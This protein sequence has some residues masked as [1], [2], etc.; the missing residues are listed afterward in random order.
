MLVALVHPPFVRSLGN[1]PA[2][3]SALTAFLQ[4]EGIDA[5]PMDWNAEFVNYVLSQWTR[6]EPLIVERLDRWAGE[7]KSD[8]GANRI[9]SLR[10]VVVPLIAQT[11][12]DIVRSENPPANARPSITTSQLVQQSLR[13]LF[14]VY[15]FG[16]LFLWDDLLHVPFGRLSEAV[17]R[18]CGDSLWIDFIASRHIP[19]PDILG[20]SLLSEQQLPYAMLLSR[21]LRAGRQDL[22]LVA[23]GSYITEVAPGLLEHPAVFDYFDHLVVHE[24]ET[25]LLR[26]AEAGRNRPVDHPNVL[27]P[28]TAR[29]PESFLVE[30]IESLPFQSFSE[31]LIEPHRRWGVTLPVYSS[32]GC[33][34]GRCAFCCTNFLRYR[35]RLIDPFFQATTRSA[36]EMGITQIQ[37][38]DEDV[39]PDRLR[40]LAEMSTAEEGNPFT[41]MVQTRFYKDLDLDLLKQLRKAGFATLEFGLESA[42]PYILRLVRKGISLPLVWRILGDCEKAGIGVIMNFMI[43]FPGEKREESEQGLR[44]GDEIG[45]RLPSLTFQ[46][47]T[48][49]VKVYANSDFARHPERYNTGSFR[50]RPLSPVAVWQGPDWVRDFMQTNNEHPLLSGRT[51]TGQKT[52]GIGV[53]PALSADPR[54]SLAPG[55]YFVAPVGPTDGDEV[56][57][58]ALVEALGGGCITWRVNAS[59]VRIL[60]FLH[61]QPRLSELKR[62]FLD[63]CRDAPSADAL[64]VLGDGISRLN[65]MGG[66]A[67][68]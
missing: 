22:T 66:I 36:R 39:R 31:A 35:E 18:C 30:D 51:V 5:R 52:D 20:L 60:Q 7:S 57:Q 3:L 16:E 55:W 38:V 62:R 23:G 32:K 61:E 14:G 54:V 48:Q 27:S 15:C 6:M 11:G 21:L 8:D 53:K 17:D 40:R 47:N 63:A 12:P 67:F 28:A 49:A 9:R 24:G 46:F 64:N 29:L 10:D 59:M 33:T 58:P 26:I 44:L 43:G 25:A 34:W 50:R 19:A 65:K 4:R 1:P 45:H 2:A 37:L 68:S 41:W 13:Q 56:R 42:S